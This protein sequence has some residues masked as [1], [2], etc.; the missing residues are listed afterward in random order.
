MK[1][2]LLLLCAPFCVPLSALAAEPDT[3]RGIS[4][5]DANPRCMERNVDPADPA[6]IV[7]TPGVPRHYYPPRAVTPVTPVLPGAPVMPSPPSSVAQQGN[8]NPAPSGG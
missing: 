7:F 2:S 6:C 3:E 4:V 5:F 1:R 8:R